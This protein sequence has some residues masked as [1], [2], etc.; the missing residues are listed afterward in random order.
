MY[1]SD[2]AGYTPEDSLRA[3]WAGQLDGD[4]IGAVKPA[5][6]SEVEFS[7]RLVIGVAAEQAELDAMIEEASVNWRLRRMPV[8]DRNILRLASYELLR[9]TDIPASVS[10]NEAIELAKR[11]GEKDSRSFVNGILD[12]IAARV[13][14]GG[15]RRHKR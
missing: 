1:R 8:I 14:R 5:D 15:R 13:G 3:L 11:F 10:I 6:Q 12:R 2:L 9:C 4:G 7:H